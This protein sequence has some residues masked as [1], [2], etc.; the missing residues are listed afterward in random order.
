MSAPCTSISPRTTSNLS[1]LRSATST[2]STYTWI[3]RRGALKDLVSFS[4]SLLSP[5]CNFSSFSPIFLFFSLFSRFKKAD[6][7]KRALQQVNGLEIAGRQIKVGLVNESN[8]ITGAGGGTLGELDDDGVYELLP[9]TFLLSSPFLSLT[10][11]FFECRWRRFVVECTF[12]GDVDGQTTK[13]SP[14]QPP[15]RPY[16]HRR[17]TNHSSSDA[18]RLWYA[19]PSYSSYQIS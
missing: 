11:Y 3:P 12:E 10:I 9:L 13:S 6:E 18:H 16:A 8:T 5:T 19:L 1:S 15:A 4:M 17:I 14:Y 2:S 7:A